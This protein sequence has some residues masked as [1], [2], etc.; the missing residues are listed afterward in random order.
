MEPAPAAVATTQDQIPPTAPQVDGAAQRFVAALKAKRAAQAADVAAYYVK[1]SGHE[2]IKQLNMSKE[3]R[4]AAA[5]KRQE[6]DK[7]VADEMSK[8]VEI[9]GMDQQFDMTRGALVGLNTYYERKRPGSF[10]LYTQDQHKIFEA[11]LAKSGGAPNLDPVRLEVE[12]KLAEQR[13]STVMA[14]FTLSETATLEENAVFYK[15]SALISNQAISRVA[16]A[17]DARLEPVTSARVRQMLVPPTELWVPP[18][19]MLLCG[20]DL[21][22]ELLE[23]LSAG[24]KTEAPKIDTSKLRS[25]ERTALMGAPALVRY[26]LLCLEYLKANYERVYNEE[27]DKTKKAALQSGAEAASACFGLIDANRVK[28]TRAALEDALQYVFRGLSEDGKSYK[29]VPPSFWDVYGTWKNDLELYGVSTE[30]E[31]AKLPESVRTERDRLALAA[32]VRRSA[33]TKLAIALHNEACQLSL[34]LCA[35]VM[36]FLGLIGSGDIVYFYGQTRV[37]LP[38][39]PKTDRMRP[40]NGLSPLWGYQNLCAYVERMR[41]DPYA[42]K[43]AAEDGL[44]LNK[45]LEMIQLDQHAITGEDVNAPREELVSG[46]ALTLAWCYYAMLLETLFAPYKTRIEENIKQEPGHWECVLC[47]TANPAKQVEC[48]GCQCPKLVKS[49][50]KS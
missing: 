1:P 41:S 45:L 2:V 32:N 26:W 21:P 9:P 18:L 28:T 46:G 19:F 27:K 23:K 3:E 42:A 30:E 11:F 24:D 17:T 8:P 12:T 48:G 6:I 4:E 47:N 31:R 43:I 37:P 36:Q 38:Q 14:A 25:N 39:R 22:N 13:R 20:P 33:L 35:A 50:K 34:E 40:P 49:P 5:K 10:R 29:S 44:N 16:V 15:Y 7:L